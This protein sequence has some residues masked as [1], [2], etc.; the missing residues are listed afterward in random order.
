MT[1]YVCPATGYTCTPQIGWSFSCDWLLVGHGRLT[2]ILMVCPLRCQIYFSKNWNKF[3]FVVVSVSVLEVLLLDITL[4]FWNN[5]THE[6]LDLDL[7]G[8]RSFRLLRM[9]RYVHKYI[10]GSVT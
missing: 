8:L 7:T 1:P 3:D 4:V 9:I 2:G 6:G 10:I 5:W